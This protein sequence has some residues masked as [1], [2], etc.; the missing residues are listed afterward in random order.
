MTTVV[1]TTSDLSALPL[2]TTDLAVVVRGRVTPDD[3]GGGVFAWNPLSSAKSDGGVV[4][5]GAGQN[6][7][8]HRVVERPNC[9][10]LAWFGAVSAAGAAAG[11]ADANVIALQSA[12]LP[13]PSQWRRKALR[14]RHV[15]AEPGKVPGR[16]CH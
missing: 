5:G 16:A 11:A 13:G 8:W 1:D 2:P 6:G 4:F 10:D 7:R 14:R 9:V 3:G 15:R 12:R